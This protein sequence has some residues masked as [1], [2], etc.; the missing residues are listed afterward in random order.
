MDINGTT[1]FIWYYLKQNLSRTLLENF[2]TSFNKRQTMMSL[3]QDTPLISF[4]MPIK[5]NNYLNTSLLEPTRNNKLHPRIVLRCTNLIYESSNHHTELSQTKHCI[6]KTKY[7]PSGS[8]TH[9]NTSKVTPTPYSPI[10]PM[11]SN[12]VKLFLYHNPIYFSL[13][14]TYL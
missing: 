8:L 14:F 13:G 12:R 11:I 3:L 5:P 1:P 2:F 4:S 9:L 7:F 6:Y 10:P